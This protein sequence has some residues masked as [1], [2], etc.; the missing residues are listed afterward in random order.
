M[1]G[2]PDFP[3]DGIAPPDPGGGY[4]DWAVL[5]REVEQAVGPERVEQARAD[6]R[7]H[8]D[9]YY[10]HCVVCGGSIHWLDAPTGGWWAHDRHPDD[11]HD[12]APPRRTGDARGECACQALANPPCAWC[13]ETCCAEHI[14]HC[15]AGFPAPCCERC[16]DVD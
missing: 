8:L 6:L 2:R 1:R 5:S 7:G 3:I 4:T 12:A 16:P 11:G 9:R 15:L 14:D 13:T 10:R